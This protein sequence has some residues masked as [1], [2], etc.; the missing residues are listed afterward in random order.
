MIRRNFLK[1]AGLMS[2]A[3]AAPVITVGAVSD[4]AVIKDFTTTAVQGRVTSAGKGIAGVAITDGI[5]VVRTSANGNYELLSNKTREFVYI[6]LPSGY[7]FP[8][9]ESITQFFKSIDHSKGSFT[10]DFDLK[11]LA[12]SD[13]NHAFVVW[14]DTQIQTEKDAELLLADPAPDLK[15]LVEAYGKDIPLHGIGCGDLV[16]DTFNLF[17]NYKKAIAMSG[18]PFFNLIGNHDMDLEAR[19]DDMSAKTFKS[20]FGPTYYSYNRGKIHYVVLDDVFAMGVAKRY[21]GYIAEDQLQWL[22]QDLKTVDKG[23][24]VIVSLHIPTNTGQALRDGDKEP[25]IGG[26]VVNREHLYAI[27]KPY[28]VHFMSGHTHFNEVWTSDNMTEHNHGTVCGA[29]WTGPICGDGTPA[30]YGVYEVDGNKVSWY[31]KST[32]KPKS[33]Q[34][35]IYPTGK[36]KDYPEEACVNVWNYDQNWKLEWFADG[37][38]MGEPEKR[39]AYDP[40]AYEL[41]FGKVQPKL[42]GWVE[43]TRTDHIFFM[44]PNPSVKNIKVTATDPFGNTY[45]EDLELNS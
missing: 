5:N 44:K 34:L 14:A 39:T 20:H 6:S 40:W 33:H 30:G 13:D 17:P 23:S 8:H 15:A 42:R 45:S 4:A 22:E 21:M 32:G 28:T 10:A 26:S 41:F 1:T 11:K 25:S 43:P 31:Y 27:L 19:T 3:I 36:H 7:E 24:T 12:V 29:W 18:I 38:A 9:Q 16:W 37:K 2:A 35:R